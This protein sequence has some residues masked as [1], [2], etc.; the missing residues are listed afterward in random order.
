M[1]NKER[2]IPAA[3]TSVICGLTFDG[4]IH[5]YPVIAN[6]I[7]S[8]AY[9][10]F[11]CDDDSMEP[12]SFD[13]A[14]FDLN[15]FA[16]DMYSTIKAGEC[17]DDAE[18]SYF[19][20]AASL[21]KADFLCSL[22]QKNDLELNVCT[23]KMQAGEGD[24]RYKFNYNMFKALEAGSPVLFVLLPLYRNK[25]EYLAALKAGGVIEKLSEIKAK[26]SAATA[27]AMT[28]AE[29]RVFGASV[30]QQEMSTLFQVSGL[31]LPDGARYVKS[32]EE[33]T[34]QMLAVKE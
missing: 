8:Y 29:E 31:E 7:I 13:L 15:K 24:V 19:A 22:A 12:S 33:L 3:D 26:L 6:T 10:G 1:D 9:V 5:Q 30:I 34:T 28:V 11:L 4:A 32:E 16:C 25:S 21:R 23:L 2:T 27:G 17:K 18:K 20:T 14:S